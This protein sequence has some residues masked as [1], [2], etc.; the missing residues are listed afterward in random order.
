MTNQ[1]P[2]SA[3]DSDV[4]FRSCDG[5][6]FQIHRKNLEVVS[7]GFS[8]PDGTTTQ[9]DIVRLTEEADTLELLFQYMYPKR[10]PDLKGIAFKKLSLLAEA[11]EKYQVYTAMVICNFRMEY[12]MQAPSAL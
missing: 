9:G 6:L 8:P 2:V 11:A 12:V 3:H 5:I 1:I 7:E 4:T 10:H